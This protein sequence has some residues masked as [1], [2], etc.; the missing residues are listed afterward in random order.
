MAIANKSSI[1]RLKTRTQEGRTRI[2]PAADGV[3]CRTERVG[4]RSADAAALVASARDGAVGALNDGSGNSESGCVRAGERA[5]RVGVQGNLVV[6][7][8]VHTLDDVDLAACRPVRA[9][10]QDPGSRF[11]GEIYESDMKANMNTK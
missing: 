7:V 1:V 9:Y 5:S 3:E 2:D 10:G 4:L 11:M 8:V 6:R